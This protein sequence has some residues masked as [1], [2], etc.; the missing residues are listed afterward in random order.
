MIKLKFK[1]QEYSEVKNF[2]GVYDKWGHDAKGMYA[3]ITMQ[4]DV[5][6]LVYRYKKLIGSDQN[7]NKTPGAYGTILNKSEL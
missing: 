7:V 5:T 2:S 1:I 6:E 4:K 3:K